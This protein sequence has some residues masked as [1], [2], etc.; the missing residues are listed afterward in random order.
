MVNGKAYAIYTDFRVWMRFCLEFE[1]F[2]DG[3]YEGVMD[4]SYLFKNL[5]PEFEKPEDYQTIIDFAYPQNVVPRGIQD[6]E[7]RILDFR[8]DSD[9]IYSAFMQDY[10]IDLCEAKMHWHKFKALLNGISENTRLCQI[11]GYR[12]YTGEQVENHDKI[13]KKL[14]NAWEL[15]KKLTEEEKHQNEEFERYFS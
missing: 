10:K 2:R 11:M 12:S 9:Y 8:I 4:I 3:G 7:E 15:P 1:A 5:L 6:A 13:Y 14:K